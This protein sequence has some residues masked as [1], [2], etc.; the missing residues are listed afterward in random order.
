MS[1]D[2][3]KN[4]PALSIRQPWA[5]FI[6]R[7]GKDVENRDWAPAYRRYQ[8]KA[9]QPTFGRFLIHAA[10]GCTKREYIEAVEFALIAIGP[11]F[12]PELPKLEDMLRGGIVGVARCEVWVETSESDWFTGPGALVLRDV[13]AVPF[14]PCRGALGFFKPTFDL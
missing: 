14:I 7:G 6:L 10:K 11:A 9:L 1:P 13:L 8:M 2:E 12:I 3:L 4:L 5:W